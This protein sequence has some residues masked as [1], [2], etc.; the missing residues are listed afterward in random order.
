MNLINSHTESLKLLIQVVVCW[1]VN[2]ILIWVFGYDG[3]IVMLNNVVMLLLIYV[4][5]TF[6]PSFLFDKKKGQRLHFASSIAG[7][8]YLHTF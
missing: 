1:L 3:S 8:I 7:W 6:S 5:N 4:I 2:Y